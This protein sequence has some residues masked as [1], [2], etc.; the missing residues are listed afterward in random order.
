MKPD[1]T[2]LV[3][4][5]AL[6]LMGLLAGLAV[7]V[8]TNPRAGLAAHLEGLMNGTFLTLVAVAVPYL[9]LSERSRSVARWLLVIGAWAN[10]AGTS[11]SAV[12]GASHTTPIAGAGFSAPVWAE[13]AVQVLLVSTVPTMVPAVAILLFGAWRS[14]PD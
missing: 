6:F 13:M 12:T 4:G 10:F 2:L 9:V 5:L 1:R 7:A 3:H 8:V 11:L 14:R